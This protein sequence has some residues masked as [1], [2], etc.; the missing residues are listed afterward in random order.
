TDAPAPCPGGGRGRPGGT[1]D[2]DERAVHGGGDHG[3]LCLQGGPGGIWR[4]CASRGGAAGPLRLRAVLLHQAPPLAGRGEKIPRHL[5]AVG[6]AGGEE[7]HR[8]P[9]L[10][11]HGG[12]PESGGCRSAA[13]DETHS[14]PHQ[15]R[16]GRPCGQRGPAAGPAGGANR[17]SGAGHAVPGAGAGGA[18]PDG[19]AA[20]GP[21]E[22]GPGT[23]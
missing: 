15:H 22:S 6:G 10:R 2:G 23:P 1:A 21:A 13:A 7:R 12:D 5:P 19:A 16:P 18:P 8:Q 17:R 14:V 3:A 11:C 9:P 4:H 20:G